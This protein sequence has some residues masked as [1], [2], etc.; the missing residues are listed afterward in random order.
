MR[1]LNYI[2]LA[3]A[4]PAASKAFYSGLLGIEPVEN[5][6]TFVLYVL[7]NGMKLGLWTKDQIEP[8][9]L[10]AGGVEVTFSEDDDAGVQATF[11]A[12]KD[13][14]AVLQQPVMMDFGFTFVVEDPDGHRVRVFAPPARGQG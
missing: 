7:P 3:A 6:A 12:W 13:K 14:A 8:A 2:L 10:T 11:E 1:T 9:P 4:N 5:S